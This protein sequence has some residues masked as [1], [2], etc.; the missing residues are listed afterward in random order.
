MD[1]TAA[2]DIGNT[3]VKT[4]LFDSGCIVSRI[5]SSGLAEAAA[6]VAGVRCRKIAYCATRRLTEEEKDAAERAGWW[7]LHSDRPLP[8]RLDYVSLSTLGPDRIAAAVGATTLYGGRP[9][10]IADAGT[11][12]TL[13]IV[14]GGSFRG[15]NISP[16]LSMR[17]R[18]LHEYTSRLPLAE[19]HA[20]PDC[21]FGSDT[22]SAIACGADW[23]AAFETA[24]AFRA[25]NATYG[26][27]LL[28]TSGGDGER[29]LVLAEKSLPEWAE[30]KWEPDLV[31]YGLK[32]AYEYNHDNKD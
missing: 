5:V 8:I 21:P 27:T 22:E 20:A 30:A 25:A 7:E 1:T 17:R 14:V 19:R 23:G 10:L 29:L 28:V 6:L 11:A 26:C 9:L 4:T 15:G 3:S 32:T 24:G 31:A 12:L 13:D 16:G 2:V 18:A